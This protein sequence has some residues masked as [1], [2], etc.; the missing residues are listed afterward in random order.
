[1]PPPISYLN[2]RA[3]FAQRAT[4]SRDWRNRRKRG[5]NP[6][7][8]KNG[9]DTLDLMLCERFSQFSKSGGKQWGYTQN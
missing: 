2:Y 3:R 8:S 7:K 5:D 4:F 6:L 9:L 1:M